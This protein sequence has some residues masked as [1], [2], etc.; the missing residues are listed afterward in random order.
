MKRIEAVETLIMNKSKK[1]K[2][3][4]KALFALLVFIGAVFLW[5]GMWTIVSEIP[6]INNPYIATVLGLIILFAT[7]MYYENTL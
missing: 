4:H 3:R 6:I 2:R 1:L 7:G 5:Y